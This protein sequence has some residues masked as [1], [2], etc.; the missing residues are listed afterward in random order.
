MR[1]CIH[2]SL[3]KVRYSGILESQ[4]GVGIQ[5]GKDLEQGQPWLD[6][7]VDTQAQD[8]RCHHLQ[9]ENA[10]FRN[11]ISLMQKKIASMSIEDQQWLACSQFFNSEDFSQVR[12]KFKRCMC[13]F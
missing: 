11:M 13:N 6:R 3:Y 5:V 2:V 4:S 7:N 10:Y 9:Q 12:F 1:V 8:D